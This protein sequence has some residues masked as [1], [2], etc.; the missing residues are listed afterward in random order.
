MLKEHG[1]K[2]LSRNKHNVGVDCAILMNPQTWVASGHIGGFSDPLIDCKECKSRYRADKIIEDWNNENNID[3]IT[4]GWDNEKLINYINENKISCPNCGK[5][6]YT[7]IRKF[8][9]MFKTFR[10]VTE[11]SSAEIYLRPD[12]RGIF[13]NFANIQKNSKKKFPLG[14]DK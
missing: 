3:L 10:G 12:C 6:N 5:L 4:D 13:V 8:N 9:L 11:D 14:S 2:S 1:G 7:N